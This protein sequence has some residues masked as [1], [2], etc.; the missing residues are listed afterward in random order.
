MKKLTKNE[1]QS[2]EKSRMDISKL[3]W[4]RVRS[5]NK[6]KVK[7]LG[8]FERMSMKWAG[9]VDGKKD[10]LTCDSDGIWQSSVLK[11]EKDSYEEF[12]AKLLGGLKLEEEEAFKKLNLL[13]DRIILLRKKH[14]ADMETLNKALEEETDFTKRRE[15]E[16]NLSEMQ[17]AA[18]RERERSQKLQLLRDK[19]EISENEL[20]DTMEMIFENLSHI[21]ENL[22][23]TSKMMDR[24][25]QHCQQRVDV[26]WRSVLCCRSNLPA[27]PE[28]VF[29]N[30]SEEKCYRHYQEAEERA[31]KLR[32][33]LET[34]LQKE[35]I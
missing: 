20:S 2:M 24:V 32:S 27:V 15:G 31:E 34:E 11:Q 35:E 18:R 4:N 25:L 6:G 33:E 1:T 19:V 14:L 5:L 12:C 3:R 29:S 21:K 13:F 8:L 9:F 10:L 28:V 22:D 7:S 16:E 23:S 26:Y 30:I 17:V